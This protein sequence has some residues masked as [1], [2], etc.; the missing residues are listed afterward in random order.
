[1]SLVKSRLDKE[2]GVDLSSTHAYYSKAIMYCTAHY[3]ACFSNHDTAILLLRMKDLDG[4]V[5][6]SI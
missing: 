1:M 6:Y 2:P 4:Y 5:L 3:V